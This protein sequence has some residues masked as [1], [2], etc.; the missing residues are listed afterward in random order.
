[1]CIHSLL[2]AFM[3]IQ[4]VV[5]SVALLWCVYKMLSQLH[6][7]RVYTNIVISVAF[8]LCLVMNVVQGYLN[9]TALL[10]TRALSVYVSICVSHLELK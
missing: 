2:Y 10:R 4:N 3:C 1:M 8:L 7:F 9:I 5:I 6:S